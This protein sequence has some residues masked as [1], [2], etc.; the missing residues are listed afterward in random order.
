MPRTGAS[1]H[2]QAEDT[3]PVGAEKRANEVKACWK[4]SVT[5]KVMVLLFTLP[6][7][8]YFLL[9]VPPC[10]RSVFHLL[11]S[12]G[13]HL[14]GDTTWDGNLIDFLCVNLQGLQWNACNRS[15]LKV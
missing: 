4:R 12:T 10:E 9:N 1:P 7:A 15:M 13:S 11:S 3:V 5:R 8:A 2:V 14:R 6:G